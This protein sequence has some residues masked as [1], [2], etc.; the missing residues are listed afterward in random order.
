MP[1]FTIFPA[2]REFFSA[3]EVRNSCL[4][5]GLDETR[6]AA[7]VNTWK[8]RRSILAQSLLARTV[9]NAKLVDMDWSF[10]VTSA[11]D[12]CDQIGKTYLRLKLTLDTGS[13]EGNKDVFMELTLDQF[14]QFLASME[15]CKSFIELM[16]PV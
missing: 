5:S 14:Y 13:A 6:V 7:I 10:G 1:Y 9:S 3:D 2:T 4:Y 8:E 12:D 15:K 16:N 11:T